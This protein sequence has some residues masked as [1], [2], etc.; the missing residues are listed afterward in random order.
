MYVLFL[1]ICSSIFLFNNVG[2]SGGT[3]RCAGNMASVSGADDN[4]YTEFKKS[5]ETP[6]VQNIRRVKEIDVYMLFLS[7]SL[8]IIFFLKR[9][10]TS[11][12]AK[13]R[14]LEI[15]PPEPEQTITFTQNYRYDFFWSHLQ[16]MHEIIVRNFFKLKGKKLMGSNFK[17]LFENG[18][19]MTILPSH[20]GNRL[21]A[22]L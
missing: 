11:G 16:K 18:T 19:N 10:V 7:I 14:V 9:F 2:T 15:W 17:R 4:L 1:S 3:K 12:G 20:L 13:R 21:Q 6:I 8:W 22:L 5:I